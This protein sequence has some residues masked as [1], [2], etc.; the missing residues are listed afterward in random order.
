MSNTLFLNIDGV[1]A[2]FSKQLS[3]KTGYA[4]E[5]VQQFLQKELFDADEKKLTA[6]ECQL[7]NKIEKVVSEKDFYTSMPVVEGA[8][9]VLGDLKKRFDKVYL[10]SRLITTHIK[11]KQLNEVCS[12]KKQWVLEKVDPSFPNEQILTTYMP[13]EKLMLS[14]VH[15]VL[16]DSTRKNVNKW[17]C[18]YIRNAN[19]FPKGATGIV[20]VNAQQLNNDLEAKGFVKTI[21]QASS[22]FKLIYPQNV[23]E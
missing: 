3:V 2:D 13:A 11:D 16:I 5:E 20:F 22:R 15:S 7:K 8:R 14:R 10:F 12:L 9:T 4:L 6:Q 17:V 18:H 19:L 1:L 21:K 23:R